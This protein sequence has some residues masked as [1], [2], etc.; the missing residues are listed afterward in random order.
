[1]EGVWVF[2]A[3]DMVMFGLLFISFVVDRSKQP[4]LFEASRR[5]LDPSIGGLNTLILL[6]SSW[7]V[8][9]AVDAAKG[10]EPLRICRS[11]SFAIACGLAFGVS[12]A[13]EYTEKLR[14]GISMLSNPFF[15]YYY[16]LTGIHLLHLAAG[17]VVLAV[18]LGKAKR[19]AYKAANCVGLETGASYWHMV[20]LLWIVLFPLLYLMR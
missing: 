2:I 18:M 10:G 12:K 9:L 20:D 17:F 8:A 19:G 4:A 13:Y 1:V 14:S 16:T 7:C 6:T 5:L 15:T 3:A 11:L